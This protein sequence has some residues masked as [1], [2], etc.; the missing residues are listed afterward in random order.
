[1][2]RLNQFNNFL[3]SSFRFFMNFIIY[4]TT[5]DP[6]VEPSELVESGTGGP[7]CSTINPLVKH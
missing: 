1:M 4:L 6:T 5:L 7:T 2:K 3:K